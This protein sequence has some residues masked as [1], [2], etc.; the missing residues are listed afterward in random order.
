MILWLHFSAPT[1]TPVVSA[2]SASPSAH[3]KD[4][5]SKVQ[6]EGKLLSHFNSSWRRKKVIYEE[7]AVVL[8]AS[9]QLCDR[10][11]KEEVLPSQSLHM[12][13]AK[14]Y[15]KSFDVCHY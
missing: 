10:K 9:V 2:S 11:A 15:H 6:P 1:P 4:S 14:I 8:I 13:E 12:R 7:L 5:L 3:S